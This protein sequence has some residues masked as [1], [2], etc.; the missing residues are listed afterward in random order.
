MKSV[1]NVIVMMAWA[2]L[3]AA[4]GGGG[5]GGGG[6]T[7]PLGTNASLSSLSV[8]G[9]TLDPAFSPAVTSYT[10]S[11][12]NSTNSV[13]VSATTSDGNA[14]FT[15]N[16][17]TNA[18]V[19]L[20]VDVNTISIVVTAENGTVSSTYTIVVTRDVPPLPP[21]PP[22]KSPSGAW[23]GQSVSVAAADVFTDFEFNS[24]GGFSVGTTPYTV[25][26]SS[27]DAQTVGNPLFY[28][29]GTHS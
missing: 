7:P 22:P 28:K 29:S 4:C 12:P 2:I 6:I 1:S 5:G 13:D 15:I 21:P 27:G 23:G 14:S 16:G 18:T 20:V 11:V 17:C 24:A 10:T 9:G 3:I 19:A 25:D 26:F 8:S